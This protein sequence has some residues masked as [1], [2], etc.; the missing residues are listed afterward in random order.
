MSV[1]IRLTTIILSVI[2]LSIL[3]IYTGNQIVYSATDNVSVSGN[4]TL[5]GNITVEEINLDL[6]DLTDSIDEFPTAMD[7]LTTILEAAFVDIVLAALI[8]AF[9]ALTFW[10]EELILWVLSGIAVIVYSWSLFDF[11][12]PLSFIF[13][14]L[15]FYLLFRAGLKYFKGV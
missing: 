4:L 9:V 6:S 14:L 10:K 1:N 2:L 11:N 3:F 13:G 12:A 7:D 15:G 5:S 8:C